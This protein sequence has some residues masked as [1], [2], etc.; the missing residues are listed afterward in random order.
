MPAS[1]ADADYFYIKSDNKLVKINYA[2]VLFAEALQN[3]VAIYTDQK[4]FISYLTFHSIEEHLPSTRFVK[5][6]SRI[7]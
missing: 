6:I 3:Y 7:S 1:S 4:K 2:D 5:R